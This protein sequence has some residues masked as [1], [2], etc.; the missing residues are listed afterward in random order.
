[1]AGLYPDNVRGI[2]GGLD[3]RE[4]LH[5]GGMNFGDMVLEGSALDLVL[6]F[7][8][9]EGAF[10]RDEL[11]LLESCGELGETSPG[12]DAMPLGAGFVI[13]LSFFQLSWVAILSTT[14]SRRLLQTL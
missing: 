2:I 3:L 10:K 4:P 6:D 1:V 9:P 14:Y 7:A 8:I 13:A 5:A 11:P 12:I